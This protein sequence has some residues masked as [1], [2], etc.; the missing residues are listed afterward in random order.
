MTIPRDAHVGL[1][2]PQGKSVEEE[3]MLRHQ[4]SRA[5]CAFEPD[6]ETD[7]DGRRNHPLVRW[8]EYFRQQHARCESSFLPIQAGASFSEKTSTGALSMEILSPNCAGL[9]VH[10]KTVK[11]CLL[12]HMSDGKTRHPSF[13]P[14]FPPQKSY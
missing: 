11:V 9:D 10:K 13:G 14:P 3:K 2:H 6:H 1:H 8:R 12:I 7:P 5:N 4:R